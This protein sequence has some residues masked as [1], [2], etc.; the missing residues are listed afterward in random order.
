MIDALARIGAAHDLRIV[1]QTCDERLDDRRIENHAMIAP[2]KFAVLAAQATLIVGHAGI[3]TILSGTRAQRPLI[4]YPRRAALGEHRSDHQ[5]ATAK[6]VEDLPGVHVAWDDADLERLILAGHLAAACLPAS[7]LR[8]SL[9]GE[10]A[11]FVRG[12]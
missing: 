12:D 1:A 7:P 2:Q 4:L 6:A 11:G 3:G 5:M 8:E 10:V 9:V